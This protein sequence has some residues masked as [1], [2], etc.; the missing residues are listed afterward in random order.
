MK[1]KKVFIS[2]DYD[3]DSDIKGALVAQAKNDDS[4]FE[5][6]DMSIKEAIDSNWKE[7]AR[8]RIKSCDCV[9]FLCG[10]YTDTAKGVTAEMSITREEKVP[11]FLLAGR[12]GTN[13]KKPSNSLSSDKVYKWTWENLKLLLEGHR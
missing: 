13:I 8:K 11:Y 9:I 2:F 7:Y 6:F 5:I 12:N 4:P 3:H 10:Y 1:K